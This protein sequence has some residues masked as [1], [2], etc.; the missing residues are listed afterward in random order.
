MNAREKFNAVMSFDTTAGNLKTEYGYWSGTVKNFIKEGMPVKKELPLNISDNSSIMG[1]PKIDNKSR[2]ITDENV[3]DYF[4]LD[5][6]IAKFP[7][8]IS[9]ML[10]EEII[11]E[12]EYYKIYKNKYGITLKERKDGTSAPLDL[13]FPIKDR[14]D[15]EN[16]KQYYDLNFKKRLPENWDKIKQDLENREFP[17]RLGGNPFG[18]LGF[19]R[20]L[21]GTTDLFMMMHDNPQLIKDFNEFFLNFIMGYWSEILDEIQVDCILIFEDMCYKNGSMISDGMFKEFLSP[22]YK[23][24]IN[25]LK[26]HGIKNII[27]DS[28]G[29]VEDIIQL[30]LECGVTGLMPFEIQAGNDLLRIRRN[31]PKLQILGGIDKKILMKEEGRNF[32]DKELEKVPVLLKQGGYVPH[33]DHHVSEDATWENF[34]YYRSKLNNIIDDFK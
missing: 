17:V 6:Y 20:H 22:Y 16:Y 31:Y 3:K 9:P 25:F 28:D 34:K 19:P 5:P 24:L 1:Y 33:I 23:R 14:K 11:E 29:Y 10:Q 8:D 18:F 27:V 12:D 32:I 21:I 7:F 30:F 13:D 2:E 26:N 4:N 15:F